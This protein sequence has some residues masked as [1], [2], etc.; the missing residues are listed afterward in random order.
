METIDLKT[1]KRFIRAIHNSLPKG[2]YQNFCP[3]LEVCKS[4]RGLACC[5][6]ADEWI[7]Y[8]LSEDLKLTLPYLNCGEFNKN[9][10]KK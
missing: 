1:F 2:A 10:N 9:Y 4:K 5:Y 8:N 3:N 7:K 6:R